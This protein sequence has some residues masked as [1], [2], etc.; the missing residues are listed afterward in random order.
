MALYLRLHNV[1]QKFPNL[2]KEQIKNAWWNTN[3]S[4]NTNRNVQRLVRKLIIEKA[5]GMSTIENN[6]PRLSVRDIEAAARALEMSNSTSIKKLYQLLHIKNKY[7]KPSRRPK[8][9]GFRTVNLKKG[10]NLS[11]LMKLLSVKKNNS[12][13]SLLN[14]M[15]LKGK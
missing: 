15:S 7:K 10:T 8:P 4:N 5:G 3:V 2:N 14:K 13:A 9:K 6:F 1:Q 11:N 12:L